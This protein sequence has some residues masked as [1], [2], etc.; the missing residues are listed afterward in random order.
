[1]APGFSKGGLAL[2]SST[3]TLSAHLAKRGALNRRIRETGLEVGSSSLF[4]GSFVCTKIKL[5]FLQLVFTVTSWQE[6]L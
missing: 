3:Q 5:N 2:F 4:Y 6:S 1:M